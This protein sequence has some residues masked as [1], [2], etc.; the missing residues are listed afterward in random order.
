MPQARVPARGVWCPAVT[1]FTAQDTLDLDAQATY[2]SYLSRT[3]LAGLVVLGTNAETFLLTR[4]ERRTLVTTA[5]RAVGP[6]FPLMAGVG[7]HS[8]VQVLEH[9]SDATEAGADYVLVLPPA[10]FG[11]ATTP[12]VLGDFFRQIAEAST[13]P[14]VIYNFPGVTNGVDLDSAFITAMAQA[15]SSI[16]GVKLTCGSVAKIT[17]LAA[18]LPQ[19]KFAVF[20]GQSDFLIGGLS[21]GSSGC[22]A[23]FANVFPK[24]ISR[25][26]TL[27]EQ[28]RYDEALILHQKAALAEQPIKAGIAATK[29]A[30]AMHS[31]THAGIK[32]AALRLRP[33]RPYSE[34]NAAIKERVGKEMTE[35]A[36]IEQSLPLVTRRD[37]APLSANL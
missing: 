36:M 34:P 24:T 6:S 22:I 4:E 27:Y 12:Q 16:V 33:R 2:F 35:V 7:G 28:G 29:Y 1:F 25:L 9:I 21:S 5:R 10:Y 26:Y 18:A 37:L 13:L 19:D 30:A 23:A 17:R 14:I 8:T 15:H 32:D 20:G 31:A 11:P 3:G